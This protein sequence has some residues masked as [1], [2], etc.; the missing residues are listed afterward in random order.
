MAGR[1][2]L[3]H[4]RTN[5]EK[6]AEIE[7]RILDI[8]LLLMDTETETPQ[9]LKRL[10]VDELSRALKIILEAKMA[11]AAA[12]GSSEVCLGPEAA[13]FLERIDA[14]VGAASSASET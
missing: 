13:A 3:H 6:I 12:A 10:R 11:Y 2:K 14:L 1:P 4:K 9:H 8:M 7:K 5:A